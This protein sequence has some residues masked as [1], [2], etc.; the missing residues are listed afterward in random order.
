[1]NDM[2]IDWESKYKDRRN[3]T[4]SFNNA[5][6]SL[7]TDHLLCEDEYSK[8]KLALKPIDTINN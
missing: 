6:K 4:T 8:G 1:M 3:Y 2:A 7:F 5:A